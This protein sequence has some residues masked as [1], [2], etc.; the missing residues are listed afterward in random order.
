MDKGEFAKEAPNKNS[1]TLMVYVTAPKALKLAMAIHLSQTPL[2]AALRQDITS[3]KIS[4]KYAAYANVFSANLAM[5]LSKNPDINEYAIELIESKQ[6]PYK[7]I[8]RLIH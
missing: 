6:L 4:S 1:E 2:R 7:P 3:I 8:Y 5:E